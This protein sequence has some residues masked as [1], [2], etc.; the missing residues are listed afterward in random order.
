MHET[1]G[2]F[3]QFKTSKYIRRFYWWPTMTRDIE[4]FCNS[5]TPCQMVKNSNQLPSGLLHT[6]PIPDWPWQ[7]IGMDFVGPLPLSMGYD[8]LLVIIDRLTSMVHLIPMTICM[9]AKEVAWLFLK[10]VV[11]LHG[12]PDSIVSDRVSK[13]TSKFWCELH[14]LMGTKLLMSTVFHPQTD[15]ATE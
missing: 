12:V 15:G 1:I 10:D 4:S 6:L 5:C 3:G 7:S 14:C 13:F 11:C 8:Y 2:H 9:T